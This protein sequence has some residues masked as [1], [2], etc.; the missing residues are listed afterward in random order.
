MSLYKIVNLTPEEA[1]DGPNFIQPGNLITIQIDLTIISMT[2]IDLSQMSQTQDY[3]LRAWVSKYPSGIFFPPGHYAVKKFGWSPIVIY[4]SPQTPP[5]DSF[6]IM[7]EDGKYYLNIL[8]L[9]NETNVFGF[10][11]TDLA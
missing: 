3:S 11:K 2:S 10:M 6:S 8:N 5:D 1:A 9:T 7:V 4:K